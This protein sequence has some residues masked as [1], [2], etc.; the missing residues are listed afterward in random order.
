MLSSQRPASPP[1]TPAPSSS[2]L[3]LLY[4]TR[5]FRRICRQGDPRRLQA[6]PWLSSGGFFLCGGLGPHAPAGLRLRHHGWKGD[7]FLIGGGSGPGPPRV[8]A[9]GAPTPPL[10]FGCAIMGGRGTVS[11]LWRA[12]PHA[13][14][15]FGFAIMGGKGTVS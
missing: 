15:G 9:G 1:H 4:I 6:R 14:L 10:G 12:L 11:S 5:L 2:F 3:R 8:A 7:G 13:P